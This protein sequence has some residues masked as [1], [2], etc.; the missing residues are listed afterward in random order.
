MS[1]SGSAS[2][3]SL[4]GDVEIL[5]SL[6][7]WKQLVEGASQDPRGL[8]RVL[9]EALSKAGFVFARVEREGSV[10]RIEGGETG[11]IVFEGNVWNTDRN[12]KDALGWREGEVFNYESLRRGLHSMNSL[13]G[14]KIDVEL[15]PSPRRTKGRLIDARAKV[16]DRFSYLL[17]WTVSNTGIDTTSD[18]RSLLAFYTPN[19]SGRGDAF[20][21]S[22]SSDL[23]NRDEASALSASYSLPICNR[24]ATSIYGGVSDSDIPGAIPS[25]DLFGDGSYYGTRLSYALFESRRRA[26]EISLGYRNLKTESRL[27]IDG[28]ILNSDS[29]NLGL[30]SIAL[31]YGD[32]VPDLYGGRS[33]L[34]NTFMISNPDRLGS[35]PENAFLNASGWI[36]DG[37]YA[38]NR[39]RFARHQPLGDDEKKRWS[40]YLNLDWQHSSEALAYAL[41]K[42]IGGAKSVRGYRESQ[43]LVDRGLNVNLEARSPLYGGVGE[44]KLQWILFWDY[45]RGT[46]ATSPDD[47]LS[48]GL[49]SLGA[50]LRVSATRHFQMRLDYGHAFDEQIAGSRIEDSGRFHLSTNFQY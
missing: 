5:K 14:T 12:L 49:S 30:P 21:V 29:L 19:L 13:A 28:S 3:F 1:A 15:M 43:F 11:E 32:A 42:S 47:W 26:I 44:G 7:A 50:G 8:E 25:L 27:E 17:N 36:S 40:L 24:W 48:D 41:R 10:I 39:F 6:P 34:S 45:G 20:S 35:S 2:E 33:F 22:W 9:S 18:W 38:I 4:E 46:V 37:R 16:E 23:K 31:S